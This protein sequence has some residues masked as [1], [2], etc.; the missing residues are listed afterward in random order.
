MSLKLFLW[1]VATIQKIRKTDAH[2]EQHEA[3]KLYYTSHF[4]EIT[5]VQLIRKNRGKLSLHPQYL[6]SLFYKM[7]Y[8][9][10]AQFYIPSWETQ[11]KYNL[12]LKGNPKL[13][14]SFKLILIIRNNVIFLPMR[15][16]YVVHQQ[17]SCTA[18]SRLSAV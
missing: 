11:C 7:K 4:K 12:L 16:I 17:Y 8:Q 5:V 13:R 10:K 15:Y 18:G 6:L 1:Q 2:I 9:L 14:P 3:K